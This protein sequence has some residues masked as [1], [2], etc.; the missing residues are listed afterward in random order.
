VCGT[1]DEEAVRSGARDLAVAAQC[2]IGPERRAGGSAGPRQ[3]RADDHPFGA[4]RVLLPRAV[5]LHRRPHQAGTHG[6]A[7]VG[8]ALPLGPA[9]AGRERVRLGAGR[10][11]QIPRAVHPLPPTTRRHLP[12]RTRPQRSGTAVCCVLCAVCRVC[13]CACACMS[14]ASCV[15]WLTLSFLHCTGSR[16]NG[17]PV[18]TGG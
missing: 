11:L 13:V 15:S 5:P 6:A 3:P 2:D 8:A 9:Q 18:Q 12:P 7:L 1:T 14:C 10:G 16:A 17:V 4:C